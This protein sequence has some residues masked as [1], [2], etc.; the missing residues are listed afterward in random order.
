ME[1]GR[2]L[3]A[4][5][6]EVYGPELFDRKV[7]VIFDHIYASY[8]DNG[9]SVYDLAD[10]GAGSLPA[11]ATLPSTAERVNDDLLAAVRSDPAMFSRLMETVFGASA[12]WACSTEQLLIREG[13]RVVEYKQTARWNVQEQ[14]KDK[15]MEQVVVKTVAGMLNDQGGTLLIGATDNGEPVGLDDDYAQVSPPNADAY[16]NW[17]DTLFE[18]TLGHAGAHRLSIRI[19]QVNHRDICRID[20]P[21][22]SRPIWV[23]TKGASDILYQRRNNSTGAIP[24][25]EVKQFISERFGSQHTELQEF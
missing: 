20:V 23:K 7:D 2:V 13:S 14:R 17:L 18:H 3:D 6:P 25:T 8:F 5:L 19:D 21:A 16:V 12:T 11:V 22:S 9:E 1:I 24:S 10:A 15:T 4:E